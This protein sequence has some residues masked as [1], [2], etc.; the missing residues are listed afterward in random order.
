MS[1][2]ACG[3]CD[4]NLAVGAGSA[5]ADNVCSGT[6]YGVSAPLRLRAPRPRVSQ[7][8]RERRPG[9]PAPAYAP[10]GGWLRASAS[11]HAR[12]RAQAQFPFLI[13]SP[14]SP[15]HLRE[16]VSS[17]PRPLHERNVECDWPLWLSI[18]PVSLPLAAGPAV[19]DQLLRDPA[20][21]RKPRLAEAWTAAPHF[22]PPRSLPAAAPP[23][24][25]P[26]A[27]PP[28]ALPPWPPL[29]GVG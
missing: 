7:T 15:T 22:R 29:C 18:M 21:P 11:G 12:Q 17:A 16:V 4:A 6:A 27:S 20:P 26:S 25:P 23:P 9:P 1:A 8:P 24:P 5:P 19:V 14:R 13:A 3:L 10:E 28:P 2:D